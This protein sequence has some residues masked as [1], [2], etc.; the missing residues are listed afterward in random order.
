MKGASDQTAATVVSSLMTNELDGVMSPQFPSS[1]IS[2]SAELFVPA[3]SPGLPPVI[4]RYTGVDDD[5]HEYAPVKLKRPFA[6]D[7]TTRLNSEAA[8]AP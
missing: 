6:S 8:V 7:V 2:A 4:T 1:P 5:G 3:G